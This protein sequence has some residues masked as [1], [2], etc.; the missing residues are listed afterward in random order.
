LAGRSAHRLGA[1]VS[2][3]DISA[4]VTF[5]LRDALAGCNRRRS[6]RRSNSAV[7]SRCD[8]C[9][10]RR[11]VRSQPERFP[12]MDAPSQ[13]VAA[14]LETLQDAKQ[15]LHEIRMQYHRRCGRSGPEIWSVGGRARDAHGGLLGVDLPV[16]GRDDRRYELAVEI[17]WNTE[18]WTIRTEAWVDA[19]AGGQE[20]LRA[21]PERTASD[22]HTCMAQIRAAV[23]D[24]ASFADLVPGEAGQP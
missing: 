24:L 2:I 1:S 16:V 10:G 8:Q 6:H 20:R 18:R 7:F 15:R 9:H 23:D 19:E 4:A 14:F 13:S 11:S 3:G 22:I 17:A 12:T 5:M 21:L